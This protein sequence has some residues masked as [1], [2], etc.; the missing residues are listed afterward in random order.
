[1]A[2]LSGWSNRKSVTL[3]RASGAVTNYQM[4]LLVG[5][6]SGATGE[7]VDCG[8]LCAADFD[9]LRFTAADGTTLLDY[10]IESVTGTTPNQLATVWIEFDSIG[11]GAT[12]FYMYYGNAGAAAVSSGANT[13]IAFDD[14]E[15]GNDEDNIDV[16]GGSITW[17]KWVN[18]TSTAK[19]DTAQSYTGTR[20]LCLHRGGLYTPYA[21]FTK[22]AGTNYSIRWMWRKDELSSP[23]LYHGDGTRMAYV[24]ASATEALYANSVS[25]GVSATANA[26]QE[27]EIN[28][29]DHAVPKHDFWLSGS[30]IADD[31]GMV[32][33]AAAANA[34]RFVNS[35][36]TSDVWVDNVLV[37]NWAATGPAWGS[38]GA[39][40]GLG[41]EAAV[42][43]S[44][45][46]ILA[47]SPS[48]QIAAN[49]APIA[50]LAI[51]ALSPSVEIAENF[52]PIATIAIL[53]LSP[54]VQLTANLSIPVGIASLIMQALPITLY[55]SSDFIFIKSS[56]G[57]KPLAIC[58][59]ASPSFAHLSRKPQATT[60]SRKPRAI[61]TTSTGGS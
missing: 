24:Y 17:T 11:T 3:S 43:V 40:E 23:N 25:L 27:Y 1:M 10:W 13:F 4:K 50:T 18:G 58:S 45:L 47:L 52:S 53:A 32:A 48:V 61:F 7:D 42:G 16:S 33:N 38:W 56:R 41:L 36:G 51:L 12:T 22:I 8:G 2:W 44:T 49:F 31:A 28:D 55:F 35:V 54:S 37:R 46:A 30:K 26:W 59:G 6:S 20:S 21:Y 5:E 15:W 29:I 14:F 39:E 60:L 34:I 57:K 9:D 19:I